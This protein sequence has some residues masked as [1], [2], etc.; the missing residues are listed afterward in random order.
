MNDDAQ[1]TEQLRLLGFTTPEA[2]HKTV[3]TLSTIT[4][5]C[6]R[7]D[8]VI[9]LAANSP[10]PD[11]ALNNL[12]R[13]FTGFDEGALTAFLADPKNLEH[14]AFI[15][16]S[17]PFLSNILARNH[18]FFN[19]LFLEGGLLETKNTAAFAEELKKTTASIENFDDMAKA[20]RLLKQKEFLRIGAR[21]LL[22]F[23]GV[24][25]VTAELSA[26]ASALLDTAVSFSIK[27]LKKTY[28]APICRETGK[29]A[30]LAVIGMGK[31]G[32][33]EL[34]FS[35]DI[36][37]LYIY[38]TDDGETTGLASKESSKISLHDFFTRASMH[39]TKL[40]SG[41]TEDGFCFRVD[42]DLRP[43]GKSGELANSLHSAEIYYE[44]WGQSWERA[45]MIKA[46]PV[47]GN[48]QLGEEFLFM[49]QPFV[50]RRH[51]DFTAI[52]EIKAMKE[53]IDLSLL[54]K[55]PDAVDAKLGRGGIR[56]VEF[57][58]QAL[59]LI[60]GGKDA[61]LRVKGTLD[62]LEKLRQKK[63]IADDEITTLKNGYIF[64]RKLEHRIQVVEGR[65]SQAMPPGARQ[66]S[67]LAKMMGFKDNG[68][69]TS[70]KVLREEYALKTSAVHSVYRSLFYKSE[71][72]LFKAVPESLIMLFSGDTT[73]NEAL[74]KLSMLGFK[75]AK[76]ARGN[77]LLLE[78]APHAM[79]LTSKGQERLKKLLPVFL[80]KAVITPD[81]DMALAHTERFVAA[82]GPRSMFYALLSENPLALNELIKLFGTS[83]FLSSALIER[84]ENLDILLSRELNLPYKTKKAFDD[85]FF[86]SILSA[87]KN[88]EEKLDALR[89]LR[90]QEIFRIGV[91]DIANAITPRQVS[92]Q[93]TFLA[94]AVIETAYRAA[95]EELGK[96]YGEPP[97]KRFAVIGM[98]KLGG[99]ELIY[100]SDLDIVFL[101][102]ETA[103]DESVAYTNGPKKI[104]NHEFFVKLGQRIISMLTLR[105]REGSVFSVDTRLR[106]SG[107]S[108]PL[109]V[110]ESAF[111][112]YHLDGSA[113]IWE[114]QSLIKA[115]PVAADLQF[116]K[117]VLGRLEAA[118]FSKPLTQADCDEMLRI[119][120]RMETEIAKETNARYNIKAGRGGLVDIEFLTQALQ[121]KNSG[122]NGLITPH[123]MKALYRLKKAG[124]LITDDFNALKTAYSFYRLLEMKQRIVHDRPEGVL[125]KNSEEL[126]SLAKRAGYAG[127]KNGGELL[128]SDYIRYA[129]KVRELYLK[130]LHSQEPS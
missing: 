10:S 28:G 97:D 122:I 76:V 11:G 24:E 15:A 86:G 18:A 7:I 27:N 16:G 105:T 71:E 30:E 26:L 80:S 52:E 79:R 5:L 66:T 70:D 14:I 59:Q 31:L 98:G 95:F 60:H 78:A 91:N 12:E 100:G 57:F 124:L 9:K 127:V 107:S 34:N 33:W 69:K 39:T 84:P 29:E 114:R 62:A 110:S 55:D 49:I 4:A 2:A 115:R 109:V 25:E 121:M 32:G 82:V 48:L 58:C 77:L 87:E 54:R 99:A 35:S 42:L 81:P 53:K 106:P 20:L 75:N 23:A 126:D 51:L 65:Q 113:S 102:G 36:D 44:S 46:R 21:D 88:Y 41:I 120:R 67:E 74:E 90:H 123:T 73:E 19:W 116:A 103:D 6:P 112:K 43:D 63:I 3:K 119:R 13:I 37:I 108:G 94:E 40:I 104:S 72:E 47:A 101:Y 68:G 89:R 125:L 64:L 129:G 111:I 45:A 50:F 38:S 128:L 61:E 130:A 93:I 56:E 17:S 117:D 1:G 8:E 92:A 22:A 83:A 96:T 85:E 118:V